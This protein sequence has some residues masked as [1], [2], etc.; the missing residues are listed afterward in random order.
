MHKLN[1][2]FDRVGDMFCIV[3]LRAETNLGHRDPPEQ[4]T[5]C[6]SSS[7]ALADLA[8]QRKIWSR[9]GAIEFQVMA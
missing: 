3:L 7:T 5:Y 8:K 9:P 6:E 2:E 4:L 1:K